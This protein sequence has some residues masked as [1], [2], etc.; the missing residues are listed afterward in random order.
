[1]ESS[2]SA[3]NGDVEVSNNLSDDKNSSDDWSFN[4][5]CKCMGA[6]VNLPQARGV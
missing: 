4:N 5:M 2:A 3:R 6:Q 1:M